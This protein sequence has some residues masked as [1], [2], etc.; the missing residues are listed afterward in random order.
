[1]GAGGAW[2][3][4][5]KRAN[6][7]IAEAAPAPIA[8]HTI[9]HLRPR[10][11][12]L[13][14][15]VFLAL[16]V[17]HD[18]VS[19]GGDSFDSFFSLWYQ[20]VGFLGCGLATL[21][22]AASARGER[23][24]WALLGS[25]L[26]MY[27]AGSVYFNLE[28]GNNPSPPFPSLADGL[29]LALYPLCFAAAALLVR[30][31]FRHV[32]ITVW[33]DGV[34]GATVVAALA[35]AVVFEPVFALTVDNGA[36]SIARLAYPLGDLIC[37]GFVVIVLGLSDRRRAASWALLGSGF[38]LLAVGDSVYVVEAA[39]GEWAPGGLLDLPYAAA[40]ML[41]AAAA[42]VAPRDD[43]VAADTAP[44]R[45]LLPAGFAMAAVGL[46]AYGVV[47][48]LN[49]VASVLTLLAL[50]A[51]V[52]RFGLTLRWL[53]R[54]HIDLAAQA[55]TDPLTGLA[56]HRRLHERLAEEVERGRREGTGVSVVALDI[57][58][59]KAINDTY[60]HSE[61]DLALKAIAK[62]LTAQARSY[63][64]VGRIGGEEFAL[65][66]PGVDPA[67]AHAVAERCRR[68]LTKLSV[69][70]AGVSCSAGVASYPRDDPEGHRLLEL[71]DGALYWAKRSG[72]AQ[73][74]TYDPREVILL[75]GA[76]QQAQVREV[77]DSASAL[78]PIFQPIVEL[79]TG[80]IGGYEALTRFPHT[81]PVRPPDQWFAQARRCGLGPALEAR[82]IAVS[83]A[84][85]DRPAGTF[86]S[87]NVSP[88]AL[89]SSE[90]ASVLPRDLSEI[91]IELTEDELFASD[92]ALDAHVAGLRA[93]GAR[94]AVDD[95]GAGYAGLQQLIRIRP[96]ILKLDRSLVSGLHEDGSKI[97]LLE[98]LSTF[99]TTTGAA[100]CGEGIEHVEELRM[101]S[102][103]DV[104]YAQ[105]Y[106]LARPAPAWPGIATDVAGEV[107]SKARWGMR[108]AA[109]P[110]TGDG[111][112]VSLGEVSGALAR[113]RSREDLNAAVR[114]I[115]RLT[116]SDAVVVS[117][118]LREERC[119]QTLSEH[120][121]SPTG[122][123]FSY[124]EY[125]TTGSVIV[126]QVLGQVIH[127][128]PAAD[129]AELRVLDR[130]GFGAVLLAPV[131]VRAETVGLLE[132]YRHTPQPW[133]TTEID[134]ARVLAHQLGSVVASLLGR[135]GEDLLDVVNLEQVGTPAAPGGQ[136]RR[137]ADLVSL[138]GQ[139]LLHRGGC[140]VL[141]QVEGVRG[142]V[143]HGSRDS[144][145]ERAAAHHSGVGAQREHGSP[146]PV[147]GHQPR[148]VARPCRTYDRLQAQ[149]VHGAHGPERDRVVLVAGLR[150]A[151]G[152]PAPVG[153]LTLS[154]LRD[155]GHHVHRLHR[156]VAHRRLLGEHHG[157]GPVEDRVG[158]VRHLRPGGPGGADHRLEHLGGGDGRHGL[159]PRQHQQALLH[160]RNVLDRQLDAQ[161]AAGDHDRVGRVDD[162]LRRSG[163][164]G[165]LDLGDQRDLAALREQVLAHRLEVVRA[166]HEG[167]RQQIHSHL[168]TRVDQAQVIGADGGQGGGHVGQ[169]EPLSR[170]HGTPHLDLGHHVLGRGGPDPQPDRSVG[171]VDHVA[172][173]HE[174]TQAVP[175]HRQAFRVA[176]HGAGRENEGRA[177]AHLGH[178]AGHRADAQL[179]PRHVAE[180]R[181]PLA[182]LVRSRPDA[183]AGLRMRVRVSVREVEPGHVHA[184]LDHAL[185]HGGL[186]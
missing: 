167:E 96:D 164:L 136:P 170:G 48:D 171:Q 99:A 70:G 177:R 98:A 152:Q 56:N 4:S 44:S 158:H 156:V 57:D 118:V 117:R 62:V 137:D 66:L 128:D 52:C 43:H 123:L 124:E 60:G 24:P 86:L 127:G 58:H 28:Y 26:V 37:L 111:T 90:V 23:L 133:T 45:V 102:R 13:A 105:G 126:N 25:G 172:G 174:L 10:H 77:L 163:C 33:L 22:R 1:M 121:W 30:K 61:G 109:P 50:L 148:G 184:L 39:R 169:V 139:P 144:P 149:L 41:L 159:A 100:V 141:E 49:A 114:L 27:A 179:R 134:R 17:A 146:R 157:V 68:S 51:V 18:L 138:L 64:L 32:G 131:V 81:E 34:I 85:P 107:T 65:V 54:Q 135:S 104:T 182:H 15:A 175:R 168:Q 29:W 72:R 129:P 42:W 113:V 186:A 160:Q 103:F 154:G 116:H 73:V 106:V 153:Q 78:T 76:E 132:L 74:R 173:L 180:N 31:H 11:L 16:H 6:G 145:E 84:V 5:S 46:T 12:I 8:P 19:F 166:A 122:E 7:S 130:D 108:L 79:A 94:I 93:R 150:A 21:W 125:P 53:T 63:D 143:A 87:L 183:P 14:A 20:P 88:S 162:V 75:S 35:A 120:D 142:L 165:L 47:E 3:G 71:A 36:V 95:A 151:L 181:N 115:E 110:A 59:F 40:T 112:A 89:L 176:L 2:R 185:E 140:T 80:R 38:A 69:H 67:G 92:E 155:L 161:V 119:V 97:A 178:P 83:L 101:L 82:A 91:V 147:G 55:A 9:R